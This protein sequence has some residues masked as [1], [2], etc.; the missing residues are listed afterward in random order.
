[1][2]LGL[3]VRFSQFRMELNVCAPLQAT[4]HDH[5]APGVQFGIGLEFL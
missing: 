4:L 2:G 1:M 3:A 5:V